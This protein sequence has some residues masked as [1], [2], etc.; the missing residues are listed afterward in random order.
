MPT[1]AHTYL[2][3][4]LH[5]S[6][7]ASGFGVFIAILFIPVF[8]WLSDHIGKKPILLTALFS[9]LILVYPLF[10][11]LVQSP[12]ITKLAIVQVIICTTLGAYFGVFAALIA[13]Q[14]PK[15]IRSTGLSISYNLAVMLF[16]GFAQF[17]VTW[18]IKV[19]NTPLSVT[20]YLLIAIS[21]SLIAAIFYTEQE[22]SSYIEQFA[23]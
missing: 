9:Y 7:I 15:E 11:W 20:Y 14:F 4:D 17:I 1:Y 23:M 22:D 12:S 10:F 3:L 2:H 21:I 8:G 16:G 19:T 5:S 18:L 6:Y 13:E